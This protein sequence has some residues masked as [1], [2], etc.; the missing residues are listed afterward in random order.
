M[1]VF[2]EGNGLLVEM[3]DRSRLETPEYTRQRAARNEFSV[4]LS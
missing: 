2:L 1:V 4:F 3:N